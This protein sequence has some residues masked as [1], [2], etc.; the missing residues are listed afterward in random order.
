MPAKREHPFK[1]QRN[2]RK[3]NT[4]HPPKRA[5]R[6]GARRPGVNAAADGFKCAQCQAYVSADPGVAGVQNRNHCPYCLWSRHVDRATAGDRLADCQARMQPIGLT[7]KRTRNKYARENPGELMVI[8][9]CTGCGKISINRI[10]ADDNS[11]VLLAVFEGSFELDEDTRA[12]LEA[13]GIAL[14]GA[15]DAGIVHTRLF[16]RGS[17]AP[18]APEDEPGYPTPSP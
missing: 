11:A 12:R 15:A 5:R 13:D 3:T 16:G 1:A 4:G 7:L 8:H 6:G 14:L 17:S 9:R 10:A 18:A 2:K